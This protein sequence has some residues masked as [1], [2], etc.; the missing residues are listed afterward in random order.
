MIRR[1]VL[2][3]SILAS[4]SVAANTEENSQN[5]V[6]LEKIVITASGFE[7]NLKDAPASISIV[8][9][10]DIEKK[11]ATTI[12]DLLTDIPGVDVR[13]G[14]GKTGNLDIG[15]RGLPSKYTLILIN[16][17]RQ[18]AS[19]D[20]APNGFTDALHA[21][22]PPLSSIERIEVIRGP[23]STMYGSDAMGGVI[24]I[25]TKK[26]GHEWH[27]N[28]RISGNAMEHSSE[29]NSANVSVVATG[30][31][32]NDKLGME[33]R[34]GFMDRATSERIE[35][36]TGRSPRPSKAHNYDVGTKFDYIVNEQ[37]SL[38]LDGSSSRQVY[39]NI[40]N[41]L[42][43]M[44]T[45]T[46][47]NGY[48]KDG[49]MIFDKN[50]I[51]L[52]HEGDYGFGKWSTYVSQTNS[53]VEGR[54]IPRAFPDVS[55]RG[56]DRELKSDN[57]LFHSSLVSKFDRHSLTGGV[58]YEQIKVKDGLIPNQTF[59]NDSTSLFL[60]D[61][62]RFID[63][64]ALTLGG[65]Y[66]HHNQFGGHFS[67]RAYLVWNLN[68]EM[69]FKGGVSTG[70]KVPTPL[71]LKEGINGVSRQ[72]ADISI[73]NPNLKP[74]KST[75]YELGFYL[76]K[77]DLDFSTTLFYTKIKDLIT[78]GDALLNCNSSSKPNQPGC[79][80]YGS[81]TQATF[82][83]NINADEA[84]TKGAEVALSY[85]IIP[86][87]DIK[88]AYTWTTTELTKG[89]TSGIMYNNVPKHA[90]NTTSTWHLTD[91]IDVY[92]QHEYKS[93]R[94][95][96]TTTPQQTSNDY[97]IWQMTD[98]KLK[99]YNLFNLGASYRY[100]DSIRIN[101]SVNNLLDKDFSKVIGTAKVGTNTPTTV[102]EYLAVTSSIAGTYIPGRNYWLSISYDF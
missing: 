23:M 8:T 3:V 72:G 26:V 10:D 32:I 88:T 45:A 52:G 58:E 48:S 64:L 77:G 66:E 51:S 71:E 63:P 70:Y 67:P 16:G 96:Y 75:N 47:I 81:T 42:G 59:K 43:E 12:A 89:A 84:T 21:F 73:G 65:R 13:N 38:W 94:K 20:I 28:V 46:S 95:R 15:I 7:Q 98:N 97:Q 22:L 6:Q 78:T 44:D 19:S 4:M 55:L 69:T 86:E 100:S 29:A 83:Q 91:H 82:A 101:G 99:G 36:S 87:W 61:E 39:K 24:N 31:L 76:D 90:L 56:K 50:Y 17:K 68:D 37:H 30:P 25:I 79:V 40:D 41:V 5:A 2:A 93:N 57:L 35:G 92:L 34:G 49:E 102:Y 62:W 54:T 60:E 1:S 85:T 27:G 53:E 18:G 14:V 74:E 33:V 11:N 80:N 9:K